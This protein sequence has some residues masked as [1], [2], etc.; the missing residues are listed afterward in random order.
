MVGALGLEPRASWS[1][2]RRASQLR[3]APTYCVRHYN[4]TVGS[5]SIVQNRDQKIGV[6]IP[7]GTPLLR[8]PRS[9]RRGSRVCYT[10]SMKKL[11]SEL[12]ARPVMSRDSA[13]PVARVFDVI[14]DPASGNFVALSVYPA[15]RKVVAARDIVSWTPE[16]T[17]RDSDS[18]IEPSEIVRIQ[19]VLDS[20]AA[21]IGNRV[22]T[23]SGKYLGRVYDFLLDVNLGAL[24]KIIVAHD[25]LGIVRWNERVIPAGEIIRTEPERIIVKDDLLIEPLPSQPE[26]VMAGA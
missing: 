14:L 11:Y 6:G 13:K 12:L 5:A 17:I 21:F 24:L 23:E 8:R 1:Q 22:E 7:R 4:T 26:Q 19:K 15:L 2:T 25:F 10:L 3:H 16:I 9:P 18:I 20:H